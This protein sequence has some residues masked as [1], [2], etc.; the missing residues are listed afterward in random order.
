[1]ESALLR[2]EALVQWLNKIVGESV[3]IIPLP[4]DAS[5][6]RYFRLQ[7]AKGSYLVMDAPPSL[8]NTQPFVAISSALRELGLQAPD[9]I[10]IDREQGFLLI[11][12]F[13]NTTYLNALNATNADELYQRALQALAAMQSIRTIPHHTMPFFTA[14]FMQKEWNWH[15]EWFSEKWLNLPPVSKSVDDCYQLLVNAAVN[16]PQVFMHRDYHAGNLMV[17]TDDIGI[18]DFQDAFI[19]PVTYD[20]ASLLRD[21]YIAWPVSQVVGWVEDYRQRLQAKGLLQGISRE[22]FL[23]WFDFMSLQRHLKALMTFAR[24]KVRDQQPQYLQHIPRTI[25][26]IKSVSANYPELKALQ[27]YAEIIDSASRLQLS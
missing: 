25:A 4:H 24:K 7:T 3:E 8:E 17:L 11:T 22:I 13:G 10:A 18:L 5:F 12:D 19:G 14:E 2:K 21:C 9:V 23:R 1:M 27:E 20:L 26:Y 15:K 16:Q 6:R